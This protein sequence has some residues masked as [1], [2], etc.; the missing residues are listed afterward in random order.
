MICEECGTEMRRGSM[1]RFRNAAVTTNTA[2]DTSATSVTTPYTSS[3]PYEDSRPV[4]K[5]EE[6]AEFECPNCGHRK[7]KILWLTDE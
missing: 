5:P 4:N 2:S 7:Q 1:Q 6:I 3:V